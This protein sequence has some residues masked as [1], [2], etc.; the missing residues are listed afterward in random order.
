MP[1]KETDVQAKTT[2]Q[3]EEEQLREAERERVRYCK[4]HPR[5]PTALRHPRLML[6]G[7]SWIALVGSTLQDGIAGIGNSV[8]AAL[9]AFDVQY[10]NLRKP[11]A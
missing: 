1:M 4:Q 2:K 5:S 7:R 8:E 9:R 10:A 11:R 3:I 6:R